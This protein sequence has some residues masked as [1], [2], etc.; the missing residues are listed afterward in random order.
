MDIHIFEGPSADIPESKYIP[1]NVM[2]DYS[3][4]DSIATIG[5][6]VA[7]AKS[8]NMKALAL[9][10]RTLA[11]AIEFYMKCFANDIKPI[12]GQKICFDS[13]GVILLCKDFEAYETLC[14]HSLE[15]DSMLE[16]NGEL[17]LSEEECKHFIC[18]TQEY[19]NP[20]LQKVFG[21]DLYA[22]VVFY[23]FNAN[24]D[25]RN[26]VLEKT[27]NIQ[28]VL[29]NEIHFLE[30]EDMEGLECLR[31][32][33]TGS[34]EK[35]R[36]QEYFVSDKEILPFIEKI[37]RLDLV[38]NTKKIA[39]SIPY[40][41]PEDY[42]SSINMCRRMMESLPDFENGEEHLRTL[43][44][45]GLE[46]RNLLA[47]SVAFQRAEYE[48][49]D[50]IA[51]G[52]TNLFLFQHELT[53]WCREKNI[54]YGPGRGADAGSLVAYL[55]GITDVNPLGY[56]LIYERFVNPERITYPDFDIDYDYEKIDD[57]VSHLKEKYG[58]DHVARIATYG[59]MNAKTAIQSAGKS[60]GFSDEEINS[61]TVFIPNSRRI[62]L[63]K[64]MAGS[65]FREKGEAEPFWKI[66]WWDG[67]KI[68]GFL[69]DKK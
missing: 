60:L 53:S 17:P 32:A 33:K 13:S 21:S 2:S 5:S 18:I 46:K 42:F 31:S 67:I 30:Q 11:G 6:L 16:L 1:L 56:G 68:K 19:Q 59:R 58:N 65:C 8:L 39:D 69:R 28:S 35:L 36:S 47:D 55:L 57:I 62:T 23:K 7:K 38:E 9:T 41:F 63:Q 10:D 20:Y 45:Q 40:I 51:R 34:Y 25:Y 3:C 52:F 54:A 49:Q 26:R 61:V 29:T 12:I 24:D 66:S 22:E 37:N 64:L 48:V 15:L 4:G 44:N 43:V 14:R 50:V 27:E